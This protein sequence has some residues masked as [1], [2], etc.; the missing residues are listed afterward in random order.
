[1]IGLSAFGFD[2]FNFGPASSHKLGV[3]SLLN[4]TLTGCH[5]CGA[6]EVIDLAERQK[7]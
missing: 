7:F 5:S 4:K 1:M 2:Q 6:R 3:T